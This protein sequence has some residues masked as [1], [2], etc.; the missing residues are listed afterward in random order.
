M[1]FITTSSVATT[2]VTKPVLLIC[3][4]VECRRKE[5]TQIN[6]KKLERVFI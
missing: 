1:I 5:D 6:K 4:I 2:T 3:R